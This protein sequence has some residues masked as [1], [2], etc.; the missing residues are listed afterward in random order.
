M[1]LEGSLNLEAAL[2]SLCFSACDGLGS[3]M[4]TEARSSH[5]QQWCELPSM[6]ITQH[7]SEHRQKGRLPGVSFSPKANSILKARGSSEATMSVLSNGCGDA[8]LASAAPSVPQHSFAWIRRQRTVNCDGHSS[9]QYRLQAGLSTFTPPTDVNPP[10]TAH[11]AQVCLTMLLC[12]ADRN[13][14]GKPQPPLLEK[15]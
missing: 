10:H 11:A 1:A 3:L 13:S 9:G 2:P 7:Y 12:K 14:H 15:L 4:S 5:Q 8:V 6:V